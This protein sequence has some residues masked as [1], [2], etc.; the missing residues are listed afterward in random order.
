[1]TQTF[2]YFKVLFWPPVKCTLL[3]KVCCVT[4]KQCSLGRPIV[5]S[6]C[7]RD[8]GS[9]A[10]E[11][12]VCP[13]VSHQFIPFVSF[14]FNVQVDGDR[15]RG[16]TLPPSGTWAG[17]WE[18]GQAVFKGR[19]FDLWLSHAHDM[20]LCFHINSRVSLKCYCSLFF[21][22]LDFVP[23]SPWPNTVDVYTLKSCIPGRIRETGAIRI[24][25]RICDV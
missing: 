11:P 14:P 5:T 21:N 20:V 1:M 18:V 8:W 25:L 23:F 24:A 10:P 3:V 4:P 9:S 19:T 15:G 13:Q 17:T 7:M 16:G 22:S 12:P 2:V 6:P